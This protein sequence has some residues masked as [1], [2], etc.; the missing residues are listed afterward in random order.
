MT[1]APRR[2][3]APRALTVAGSDSS[4]GAGV[5]ADLQTFSLL[6][7]LGSCAVTA[8]TA[9]DSRR[10]RGIVAVA[11]RLVGAQIEAVLADGTVAAA[12]TGML[13]NAAIVRKVARALLD[14]RI[15][16]LVV[17]PVLIST[18]GSRLL[19]V[20]GERALRDH[21]LPL[22]RL[23]TPNLAEAAALS[24][25]EVRDLAAAREAGRAILRLGARAVL[26]KGGHLAGEPIDLL[27]EPRRVREIP[28]RRIPWD[29]H[30]TGC[31]LSA[32]IAAG[33]ALGQGLE[34]AVRSGKRFLE[35]RLA[36]AV[37]LPSGRRRIDLRA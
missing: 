32:A 31:V 15:P 36:R 7:V 23:V 16:N 34:G 4:A 26:V 9:Q 12:K 33:L 5:Q 27:V 29:A 1:S 20:P 28:G 21:L 10:V 13:A 24:G 17:D 6:G 22:A 18:S 8:V 35:D 11:P 37:P 14:A 19:D 25:I 2:R 30:G 3:I